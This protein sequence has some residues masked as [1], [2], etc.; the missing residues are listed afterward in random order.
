MTINFLKKTLLGAGE[1]LMQGFGS[2]DIIQTKQDQSNIVTESDFKSEEYI[3]KSILNSYPAHNI[4]GEENGY[5]NKGSEYTWIFDPL[6][7]TSNYAAHIPWFGI[8]IALLKDNTP[9]LGGAYLPSSNEMYYAI[10][11]EGAY[12]NDV[13]IQAP[14]ETVLKNLLCCYSLDFSKDIQKTEHEV[15]LI[16]T[17][18]QKCRNLRSTNC[19]ID[20]CYVAEGKFGATINQTMKIWDIAAPQLILQESGV[21]VTDIQGNDIIYAPSENSA[22][23]N[24]TALA[25]NPAIHEQIMKIISN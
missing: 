17:L 24:F 5:E 21:K 25:A 23:Q 11:G 6:D 9:V 4:L 16:K 18:V 14:G 8:L 7:G 20:F 1:I 2:T 15:Q 13:Q 3:R 19:L 10:K 12:K 22:E